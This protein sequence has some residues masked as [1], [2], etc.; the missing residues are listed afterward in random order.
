MSNTDELQ[1]LF[2]SYGN[3]MYRNDPDAAEKIAE[4]F[5]AAL[6]Q[7]PAAPLSE[8]DM[9][10]LISSATTRANEFSDDGPARQP[11]ASGEPVAWAPIESV[12]LDEL[13]GLQWLALTDGQVI[14][15]KYE[16]RQ[17]RNPD[18]FETVGAGRIGLAYV[19]HCMPYAAPQHP[20]V[21]A[22]QPAPV[23]HTPLLRMLAQRA[24]SFP[25]FPIGAHIP[26][27]FSALGEDRPDWQAPQ[28]APARV[29]LPPYRV[30]EI[31]IA[32][33][34]SEP[35]ACADFINGLRHGEAAHG[36]AAQ[37]EPK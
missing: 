11:A 8:R 34:Y 14:A 13:D 12:R 21:A 36:I 10:R 25:N 2:T 15:G 5:S 18:G 29:P 4:M 3:A 37:G 32:A 33:G 19:T 27:V 28:P 16:W 23:D 26:E 35:S 17:G 20:S 24:R 6:A 7:Q 31:L 30:S 1:R 9:L 22:P